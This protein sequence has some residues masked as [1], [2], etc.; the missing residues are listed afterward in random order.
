MGA[1]IG[2]FCAAGYSGDDIYKL[3]RA[4]SWRDVIDFSLQYGFFKG[5]KLQAYL[6]EHLPPTFAELKKPLAITTTDVETGE[7]VIITEGNLIKALRASSSY[8]GAFEPLQF[9]GRTLADGGIINNLPVEALTVLDANYTVASDTTAP[10]RASVLEDEG[11]WWERFLATV[12]FERRNPMAQMLLRSSDI[13][14]SILTEMQFCLHPTDIRVRHTMPHINIESFYAF[15]EI[16]ELGERAAV[17]TF[18][19]LGL[20]PWEGQERRRDALLPNASPATTGQAEAERSVSQRL[21][22]GTR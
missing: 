17:N 10:R 4:M 14:Q 3:A 21:R 9:R 20:L 22:R 15:E 12:R 5:E 11:K 8:P 19:E 13:M 1:I 18:V 6:S 7:E 2:A 16:V